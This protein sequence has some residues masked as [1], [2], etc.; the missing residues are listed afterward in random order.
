MDKPLRFV[1]GYNVLQLGDL[2]GRW[3][4]E[5]QF[6]VENWNKLRG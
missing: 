2:V 1:E 6:M 4:K 3:L 5:A